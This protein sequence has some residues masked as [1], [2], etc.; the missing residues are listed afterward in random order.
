MPKPQPPSASTAPTQ[1]VTLGPSYRC[2]KAE[3]W[4]RYC[5]NSTEMERNVMR[6]SPASP[7]I[8]CASRNRRI[9]GSSRPAK[10]AA[11]LLVRA[12]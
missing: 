4:S 5:V 6:L 1:P 10:L 9:S 8:W 7:T 2:I 12:F 11:K 3:A